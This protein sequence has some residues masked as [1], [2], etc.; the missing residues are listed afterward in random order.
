M[1]LLSKQNT[2]FKSDLEKYRRRLVELEGEATHLKA[3]KENAQSAAQAEHAKDVQH[4]TEQLTVAANRERVKMVALQLHKLEAEQAAQ[5]IELLKKF[6]PEAYFSAD[7]DGLRLLLLLT[8]LVAKSEIISQSVRQ[9]FH[10][11]ED[12]ERV[13]QAGDVTEEQW[14]FGHDINELMSSIHVESKY[15]IS[16]MEQCSVQVFHTLAGVYPEVSRQ[17]SGL[18]TLL[19]QMSSNGLDPSL[20]LD[21]IRAASRQLQFLTATHLRGSHPLPPLDHLRDSAVIMLSTSDACEGQLHL[22]RHLVMRNAPE[23]GMDP[24]LAPLLARLGS[25]VE[26]A[27]Q[28]KQSARRIVRRLPDGKETTVTFSDKVVKHSLCICDFLLKAWQS[29]LLCRVRKS[30]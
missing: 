27:K 28:I 23:G 21:S 19:Q 16:G 13:L 17:E 8:R 26:N 9:Q 29:P 5:H 7:Y 12:M 15:F 6:M 4:L 3:H 20:S 10:L 18:D 30:I 22:L 25:M 1:D 24:A 11:D 2:D 14:A